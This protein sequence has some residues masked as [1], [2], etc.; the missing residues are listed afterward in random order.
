MSSEDEDKPPPAEDQQVG[1]E[2]ASDLDNFP[3]DLDEM[4]RNLAEGLQNVVDHMDWNTADANTGREVESTEDEA[5]A[6]PEKET[7]GESQTTANEA[8][9]HRPPSPRFTRE[10]LRLRI[11]EGMQEMQGIRHHYELD[12]E[13]MIDLLMRGLEQGLFP[14]RNTSLAGKR[15]TDRLGKYRPKGLKYKKRGKDDESA[16]VGEVSLHFFRMPET[17]AS[18]K[19]PFVGLCGPR[20]QASEEGRR[21][22]RR[23]WPG[24]RPW[25]G[26]FYRRSDGKV[27]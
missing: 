8:A 27:D 25:H 20:G 24:R 12:E 10:Q 17:S 14:N 2:D 4:L 21:G 19:L 1:G 6:S 3:F 18:N 22:R 13:A 11:R 5:S 26:P 9:S 23:M 7:S 16:D 15:H